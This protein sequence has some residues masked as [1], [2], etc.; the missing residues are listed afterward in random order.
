M[1]AINTL[2]EPQPAAV[3]RRRNLDF[4]GNE[5]SLSRYLRE[6]KEIKTLSHAEEKELA[7]R[8]QKGDKRAL[9]ALV[10]AN[11]KFVVAV[12]R[13]YSGR[14]LP[15]GDLVN[16]GNLGLIRA[17]HR[18]DG[19]RNFKFF[20]YAVWW[21][22]QGILTALAEQSHVLTFST[23]RIENLR[24]L[25]AATRK[26]EQALHREPNTEELAA[27]TGKSREVIQSSRLSN[28]PAIS[29]SRPAHGE[30]GGEFGETLEDQDGEKTD[31]AALRHLLTKQVQGMLDVLGERERTVIQLYFGIGGGSENSLSDIGLRLH[32]TRE[33]IRQ[34][35]EKA[36]RRLLRRAKNRV[37]EP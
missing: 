3:T 27:A 23:S 13:N 37:G 4:L 31:T 15:F 34:I 5:D 1:E 30:A 21:I 36:L 19:S 18:Y 33:R 29:L 28:V 35:K 26:L 14:G 20:S 10:Q 22:R 11:L 8:A 2:T 25:N 16:E 32:L 12:C 17:A 9:H 24:T 6:I 7:V